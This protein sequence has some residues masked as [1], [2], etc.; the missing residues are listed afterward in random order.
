MDK[1]SD[2]VEI[3]KAYDCFCFLISMYDIAPDWLVQDILD[4]TEKI[5]GLLPERFEICMLEK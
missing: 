4:L 5:S 2:P 3:E 1:L